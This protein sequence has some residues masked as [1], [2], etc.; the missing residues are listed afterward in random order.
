MMEDWDAPVV[1]PGII[2]ANSGYYNVSKYVC[3]NFKSLFFHIFRI[4]VK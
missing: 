3:S 4:I 2:L 1:E